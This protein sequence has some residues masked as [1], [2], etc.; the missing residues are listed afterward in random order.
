MLN[1]TKLVDG[2]ETRVVE[3]RETKGGKL[4][5]VSRNY[6]AI[7]RQTNDVFY[8]GED[9]NIYKDGK[10]ASHEGT[11]LSGIK[12]A[13]FGMMIPGNPTLNAKCYQEVAPGTAMDR[14]EIVSMS[15]AVQTPVGEFKNCLKLKETSPLEP[16]AVGY[17]YYSAG[18]CMV[19]DGTLKLV[20]YGKAKE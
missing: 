11:W 16:A 1:E 8:F 5:E 6:L 12:G 15:E 10:V 17:K 14:V 9:V 4:H 19:Q 2:V 18:I 20:R 3:E 13:R 7:S